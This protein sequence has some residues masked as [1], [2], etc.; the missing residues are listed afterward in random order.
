[1][2][3]YE[4][5]WDFPW[6]G[7]PHDALG[8]FARMVHERLGEGEYAVRFVVCSTD[9]AGQ[10]CHCEVGI[11]SMS[12]GSKRGP[13]EP[14]PSIFEFRKRPFESTEHFNVVFLVPTGINA[15][16]GGHA[17][18]AG[19]VA[20]LLAGVCDTLIVHPNVVNASDINEMPENALYVEGSVICRLLLGTVALRR[21]RSNRV[22]VVIDR[23]D[24]IAYSNAAINAVNAARACYGFDCPRIVMLDPPVKLVS[25]YTSTGR[26]AG[27]VDNLSEFL[28]GIRPYLSEAD[29]IAVSS[30]IAVP[31]E[32]HQDYFDSAGG[33]VN[34]WGGVEAIF[35]HSL[36]LLHGMP[37]AHSPMIESEEIESIDPGVVD[38]R[39][40]AEAVSLTFL[41]SILKGLMRSPGIETDP[42]A[43]QYPACLAARDVSC[44]VIPDGC[45]G[46]PVLAALEQ[47]IPV[48]AVNDPDHLMANDLA[49]LP[50][51]P[52][53]F[54]RVD[55]YLEA[56]GVLCARKAGL[57][58]DSVRRPIPPAPVA[59]VFGRRR[60]A[61]RSKSPEAAVDSNSSRNGPTLPVPP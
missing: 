52:G 54:C 35:T 61:G 21:V 42:V 57:A 10:T 38:P 20:R 23:H 31:A 50:W 29:A 8:H 41:Q 60:G 18:D 32:F 3:L 11:L 2:R 49:A 40:A 17:G 33:M 47:G 5:E 48:I 55:N 15:T 51:S 14:I 27:R 37:S 58:L 34:P 25:E 7:D 12:P 9:P 39:M 4:H 46:L 36:S 30:V 24:E 56:V 6:P 26:A 44:L 28:D 22:L 19:P 45:L 13:A 16:I 53:Q 1:M 59:E 43:M